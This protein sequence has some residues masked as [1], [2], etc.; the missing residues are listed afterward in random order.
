M[1]SIF[2]PCAGAVTK[3]DGCSKDPLFSIQVSDSGLLSRDGLRRDLKITAPITGF[4]LEQNGNY[5]FLH[6]VNDF[7]YVYS[8]GNR[9]G[10]LTISGIGFAKTCAADTGLKL[11]TVLDFY[12]ENKL[13]EK[14]NLAVQLG[15]CAPPFFAFL[16]GMRMEMQDPRTLVAQWSLRF[17]VMPKRAGWLTYY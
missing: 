12:N 14:G 1:A 5:Q 17:N 6:T 16:T 2:S 7:I 8:F 10:E 11:C 4:A 13:T 9:V 15:D 3:V